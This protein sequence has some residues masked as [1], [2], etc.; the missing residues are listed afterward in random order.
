MLLVP[1]DAMA[2]DYQHSRLVFTKLALSNQK[3]CNA[4][5]AAQ[6]YARDYLKAVKKQIADRGWS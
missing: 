3:V 5:A 2:G 4:E 6:E 1:E